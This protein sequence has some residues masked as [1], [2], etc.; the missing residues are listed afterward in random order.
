MAEEYN[1]NIRTTGDTSGA[2]KVETA[3][4]QVKARA[5]S[6]PPIGAGAAASSPQLG[7]ESA[8]LQ[9]NEAAASGI[10]TA[11]GTG[12]VAGFAL[13][14]VIEQVSSHLDQSR[15]TAE[16]ESVEFQKQAENW[17][18]L[19]ASARTFTDLQKLQE[20]VAKT[21]NSLY[22]KT[23]QVQSEGTKGLYQNAIDSGK[24]Y[25]NSIA[26]LVGIQS[27]F[28]TSTDQEIEAL[29]GQAESA[30]ATGRVYELLARR[31]IE[32]AQ[33]LKNLPLAEQ[34]TALKQRLGE[35]TTQQEAVDKSTG[36]GVKQFNQLQVQIDAV[37]KSVGGLEKK[38]GTLVET[39]SRL[40]QEIKK[41]NFDQLSKPE[42]L[43]SLNTDLETVRA[44]LHDIGIEAATPAQALALVGSEI[45]DHAN[46]V[47]GLAL[48]WIKVGGAVGKTT[49]A[50]ATQKAQADQLRIKEGEEIGQ[51]QKI[52][53]EA[54]KPNLPI[55]DRIKLLT[56]ELQLLNQIR[57]TEQ[58][59]IKAANVA[60]P[61]EATRVR[62][63]NQQLQNLPITGRPE[64]ADTRGALQQ[65]RNQLVQ[66]TGVGVEG[67]S[68]AI[69][70]T[71]KAT[72]DE[73][74]RLK[75]SVEGEG[76]KIPPAVTD[77]R[78]SLEKV[79]QDVGTG[80]RDVHGAVE[81]G[82]PP[83]VQS[84][85]DLGTVL[86]IGF[87]GIGKSIGGVAANTSRQIA[88]LQ[89]QINSLWQAV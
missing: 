18:D 73:L 64:D 63:L 42:Q 83:V 37:G 21:V 56:Q 53:A 2:E 85:T 10:S 45:S 62:D 31:Q 74:T 82:T 89:S 48:E 39:S 24:L 34:I 6:V 29:L 25:G 79:L 70:T 72:N 50:I 32:Y 71:I 78:T 86:G 20:S 59:R 54:A 57:Q 41:L 28:K 55:G 65:E 67:A 14:N 9:Q 5:A 23:R 15:I 35:L 26:S 47:R 81:Q 51:L 68:T 52:A 19:A 22:E 3:L 49:E 11:I 38:Q 66:Q 1:V 7:E 12:V 30:E 87:D 43:T 58:D 44:K 84:V 61:A 13:Q 33:G 4:D 46:K 16:K 75:A 36:S 8:Q 17:R 88:A 27:N 60:H 40:N 76:G 69:D 80:L 77:V